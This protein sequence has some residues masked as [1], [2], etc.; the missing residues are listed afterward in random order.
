MQCVS[1]TYMR[2]GDEKTYRGAGDLNAGAT[3]LLVASS[4][5]WVP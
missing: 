5:K 3:S 4:V 2:A 1:S